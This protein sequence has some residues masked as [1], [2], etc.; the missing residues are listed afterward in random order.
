VDRERLGVVFAVGVEMI[1][2]VTFMLDHPH[3]FI[4]GTYIASVTTLIL[5]LCL[6]LDV[7]TD[8]KFGDDD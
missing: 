3:V 6:A 7:W 8:V 2:Y 4:I 1:E 5:M